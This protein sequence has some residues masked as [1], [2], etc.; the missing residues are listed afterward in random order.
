[1]TVPI[2]QSMTAACQDL[3]TDLTRRRTAQPVDPTQCPISRVIPEEELSSQIR[4]IIE[5]VQSDYNTRV[6][7]K[8]IVD[9]L[10][11]HFEVTGR[12]VILDVA[13]SYA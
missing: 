7:S 6:D 12:E 1:M 13:V 3:L 4:P 10:K 9:I 5:K 2:H 8:H 11:A